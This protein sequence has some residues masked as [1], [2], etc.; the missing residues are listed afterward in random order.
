MSTD[1]IMNLDEMCPPLKKAEPATCMNTISAR[2]YY[3]RNS[4]RVRV[5]KLLVEI[6]R[7]GRCVNVGTLDR[8]DV[9]RGQIVE[10]WLKYRQHH[11]PI[12]AKQLKMQR[13][14]A[15]WM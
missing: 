6:A 15:G 7:R 8:L 13:L 4:G 3:R 11:E 1:K 9:T 12:S 5:H 14:V 10:A 2:R